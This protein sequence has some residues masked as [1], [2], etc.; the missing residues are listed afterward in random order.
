MSR[1]APH[2]PNRFGIINTVLK[3]GM[4]PGDVT[5]RRQAGGALPAIVAQIEDANLK[6]GKRRSL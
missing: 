5:V 3:C 6:N 4:A 1:F 2:L